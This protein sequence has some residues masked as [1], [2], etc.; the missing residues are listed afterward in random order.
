MH[1]T[2]QEEDREQQRDAEW[3]TWPAILTSKRQDLIRL[4]FPGQFKKVSQLLD[5]SSGYS[6][7]S[8]AS[9]E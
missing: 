7:L 8:P 4:T 1:I 9:L 3:E 5:L 6:Q 2:F